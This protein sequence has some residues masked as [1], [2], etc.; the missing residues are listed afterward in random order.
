MITSFLLKGDL[1]GM[2]LV[3]SAG[4]GVAFGMVFFGHL[5]QRLPV[6]TENEL[7]LF[8]FSGKGARWLHIFRSLYVGGIVAPLMLSM[9]FLAFARVLNQLLG[10]S[11]EQSILLILIYIGAGTFFNSLK[12]RI[13]LD[14]F[15]LLIFSALLVFIIIRLFN[16]LG[17]L[18]DIH[19]VIEASDLSF[20][21]FPESG[22]NAFNAFLVFVLIQWWAAIIV[23]MPNSEG[24][25]LMAA[26]NHYTITKSIVLPQLF[27]VVF[28][29]L[30]NMIPFYIL[31]IDSKLLSGLDEEAAFL[32]IFTAAFNSND[33][34]FVLLFFLIPFTVM[35]HNL[36]N[37]SGAL[38]TQNF[39]KYY[40]SPKAKEKELN[41][42]GTIAML[43]SVLVAAGFAFFSDSLLGLVKYLL[44][45]TAGVGPVFILRWYWYR[46]NAWTQLTAMVVSLILPTVYDLLYNH[47][48]WFTGLMNE[49]M[50]ELNLDFFP[51]KILVLSIVVSIIWMAVMF[52][53]SKTDEKTL[54]RFV[55]TLKPGGIWHMK[56]K[57][58]IQF[59][60]RLMIALLLTGNFILIYVILW[61]LINGQYLLSILLLLSYAVI[62]LIAYKILR[63]TNLEHG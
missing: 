57:G 50:L 41:Y 35:T 34:I 25:K 14:F 13:R 5:W 56:N 32:V 9:S 8:R 22:T 52:L 49:V 42:A 61:Y 59:W 10:I 62:A 2:W 63:Q 18:E 55:D 44:T 1:S 48:D 28:F 51:L 31:L 45:I 37:W 54:T 21:L 24:Q 11:R 3:W 36:Q 4:F 30:I 26:K 16:T 38:L 19:A 15:L 27:F 20:R 6:K 47:L 40:I 58:K 60:K 17:S 33:V 23:D 29:V 12:E 39:Y 7:L 43:F 53:T 46:I